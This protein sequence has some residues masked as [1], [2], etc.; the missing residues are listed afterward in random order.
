MI[1]I[2]SLSYMHVTCLI[3]KL[4]ARCRK[5]PKA[6]KEWQAFNDLKQ[7]IDDFNETC[8]L[9][10][11]MAHPAMKERHWD[12]IAKTTG[13]TFDFEAENFMLRNIMEAPLLK[14]KEDIEVR[15][16]RMRM[17]VLCGAF[18]VRNI[19]ASESD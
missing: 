9:L 5:L 19:H 14:N 12:R 4:A 10:E 15:V 13:H 1:C 8:P 3:S 7:K 6:L 16:V 17:R 18:F 2:V 11:L